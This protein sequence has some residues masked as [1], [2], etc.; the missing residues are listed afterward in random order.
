MLKELKISNGNLELKFNE[1]T[2]EYTVTV[3][4]SVKSLELEYVLDESAILEIVDNVLDEKENIVILNVANDKDIK[5]YKLYV[6]K[7]DEQ[8]VSG[9]DNYMKE[10][11]LSKIDNIDIYK[12]QFLTIGIFLAIIIVFSI[13]FRKKSHRI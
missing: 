5:E 8:T 4:S 11:E 6:Y 3:A 12:V 13:I 9:I 10:L 2:Y 1:Y 7:E